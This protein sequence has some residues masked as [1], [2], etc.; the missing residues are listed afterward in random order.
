[1]VGSIDTEALP[2]LI[3]AGKEVAQAWLRGAVENSE[4]KKQM[5]NQ[6]FT[7]QVAAAHVLAM[8]AFNIEMQE[9]RSGD[10]WI[11]LTG[12]EIKAD[13]EDIRQSYERG[14][15]ELVKTGHDA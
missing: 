12:E 13:L 10:D 8:A 4:S 14:E 2:I 15:F 1:M 9:Q 6:L 3:G 7:L 11:D 5:I